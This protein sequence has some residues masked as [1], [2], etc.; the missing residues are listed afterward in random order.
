MKRQEVSGMKQA[1]CYSFRHISHRIRRDIVQLRSRGVQTSPTAFCPR[2]CHLSHLHISSLPSL[3]PASHLDTSPLS[4]TLSSLC[5]PY[6]L[7][8]GCVYGLCYR[9]SPWN[10]TFWSHRAEKKRRRD[11]PVWRGLGWQWSVAARC[12]P[13]LTSGCSEASPSPSRRWSHG[14]RSAPPPSPVSDTPALSFLHTDTHWQA[15]QCMSLDWSKL[16]GKVKQADFTNTRM[17]RWKGMFFLKGCC[18]KGCF[19]QQLV[20]NRTLLL[21][22]NCV[23]A[24]WMNVFPVS[25]HLVVGGNRIQKLQHNVYIK[26]GSLYLGDFSFHSVSF[27]QN[28]IPEASGKFLWRMLSQFWL[29]Q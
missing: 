22:S 18:L 15:G 13:A 12:W 10:G 23:S 25:R 6:L 5:L 29:H 2:R 26:R 1:P 9:G 14:H 21:F 17:K 27:I 11:W 16:S 20:G 24:S 8:L 28:A 7:S 3:T 19:R 4:L